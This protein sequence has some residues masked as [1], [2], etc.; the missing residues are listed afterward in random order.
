MKPFLFKPNPA[1]TLNKTI[2]Q[3]I[4]AVILVILVPV[5]ILNFS[6]NQLSDFD[7]AGI[8][9]RLGEESQ[10]DIPELENYRGKITRIL[11]TEDLENPTTG[12]QT[13]RQVLEIQVT[14]G[15]DRGFTF[16]AERHFNKANQEQAFRVGEQ[17][18][19]QSFTNEEGQTRFTLIDRYRLGTIFWVIIVF[20]LMVLILS[21]L[22]G[23]S[24]FLA[25][26]LGL[27]TLILF[28]VPNILAGQNILILTFFT[29][30]GIMSITLFLAHG[31]LKRTAVALL[32][33][34]ITIFLA[35]FLA[36]F[37]VNI[38]NLGGLGTDDA[39]QLMGNR[40]TGDLNLRGLLL[41]GIIIGMLG[42]LDDVTTAQAVAIEEISKANPQLD[43]KELFVRGFNIG[44]EHII[45][46]VNTLSF[47]YIGTSLPLVIVTI[48]FRHN[49][50]WVIL[51]SEVIAEEV[52][53]TLVGSMSLL[54][55]MPITTVLASW[56]FKSG[57][58]YIDSV[59]HG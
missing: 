13:M 49:N 59:K 18:L 51:N 33:T 31:F 39:F 10:R 16:T 42:V 48:I 27:A 1:N 58:S 38:T 40:V 56:F 34:V 44:R 54:M 17:V 32:G 5:L 41:S 11:E 7:Q 23:L 30:V 19:V 50:L 8:N 37:I 45:S 28:V 57:N 24:S 9:Q 21:G 20:V 4:F 53:R 36:I 26:I 46:M 29:S 3:L 35:T 25:M 55:A 22:R 2:I 15:P 43:F 47:A 6:P 12:I 52:V 14:Q